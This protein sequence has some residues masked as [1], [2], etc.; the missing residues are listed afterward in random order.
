MNLNSESA[1]VTRKEREFQARRREIMNAAT[2]L[3]AEKGYHGTAMSEIAKEAEFS[4]GSLYNF[5]QNKEELYFTLLLEKIDALEAEVMAVTASPGDV[6]EKLEKLIDTIFSFFVKE[7]DFWRIFAEHQS[8]FESGSKGR[9]AGVVHDKYLRY[10]ANMVALMTEGKEK[11][12]FKDLGPDEL[13]LNFFGIL[14]TYLFIFVNSAEKYDLNQKKKIVME[15][16]FDGA[17]KR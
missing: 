16:F 9:F 14:N 4:T 3:F 17:R 10:I 11:G 7:R 5:F 15:I 12:L 2:R 1:K 8:A 13:A 6:E